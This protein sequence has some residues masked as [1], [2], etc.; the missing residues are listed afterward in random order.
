[1]KIDLFSLSML[2]LM[3]FNGMCV[4]TEPSPPPSNT[5]ISTVLPFVLLNANED[6]P[7]GPLMATSK[8]TNSIVQRTVWPEVT[9]QKLRASIRKKC[10][11]HPRVRQKV[12]RD[13]V[14][15]RQFSEYDYKSDVFQANEF[16]NASYTDDPHVSECLNSVVEYCSFAYG[17][18]MT[19]SRFF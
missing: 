6:L 15:K 4:S 5:Q 13:L 18:E 10:V 9:D 8:K 3:V 7:L 16:Y 2:S 14:H 17:T 1:M 12:L 19:D 11:N